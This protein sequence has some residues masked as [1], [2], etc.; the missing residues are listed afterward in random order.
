MLIRLCTSIANSLKLYKIGHRSSFRS[1]NLKIFK[2]QMS[3]TSQSIFCPPMSPPC[4]ETSHKR[5]Y[6]PINVILTKVSSDGVEL[7]TISSG[8][9]I[10]SDISS[11][12][13]YHIGLYYNPMASCCW[14]HEITLSW[15]FINYLCFLTGQFFLYSLLFNS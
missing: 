5:S 14:S 6:S 3:D 12:N 2:T 13:A 4:F 1:Q 11:N 7:D 9:I 15:S 8:D 10:F